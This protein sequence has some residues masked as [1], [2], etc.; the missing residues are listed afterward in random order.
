M[1]LTPVYP[2]DIA[3]AYNPIILRLDSN[4]TNSSTTGS[5]KSLTSVTNNGG[6][7][8]LNF[9]APHTLVKGDYVIVFTS[10]GALGLLGVGLVTVLV[11]SD[12]IVINKPFVSNITSNGSVFK[13]LNNYS[14]IVNTY[15]YVEDAPTT[16][17]LV[18]S[19]TVIPK[20][21]LSTG[22]LYFEVDI[23][24]ILK[25]FNYD[26][27][28]ADDVMSSDLYPLDSNP[29]AQIN[30]KSFVKYHV[31]FAEAYDNPVGGESEYVS[32]NEQT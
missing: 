25:N 14:A 5:S 8:Q 10:P 22:F 29:V 17:E 30:K 1:A 9:S 2:E 26:G 15:I 21:N 24:P 7:A 11:D 16:P 23:A 27:L 19:T 32:Q 18:S 13:Y 6:F 3:P 4:V 12:S 20:K 31:A 28:A